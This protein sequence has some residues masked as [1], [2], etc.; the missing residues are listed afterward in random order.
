MNPSPYGSAAQEDGSNH[1]AWSA[2]GLLLAYR[3][4]VPQTRHLCAMPP[5]QFPFRIPTI[6]LNCAMQIVGDQDGPQLPHQPVA[7]HLEGLNA[8]QL[9]A[10][11]TQ[12][13]PLLMLAGAGTGK[14]RALTARIAHL[15]TTGRVRPYQILAV[16]F[17]NK[18]AS[19]MKSRLEGY[20]GTRSAELNWVGTF[21][22]ISGKILR[23]RAELVELKPDFTILDKMDQLRLLGQLVDAETSFDKKDFPVRMLSRI[24]DNWKN[25]GWTPEAVPEDREDVYGGRGVSLYKE[26]Q[27]RL[28]VLNSVD[29]GDLLL[30]TTEIF[31]SHPR[32][33]ELYQNRFRF[34]HVDEYQDTN[35]AQYLWLRLLAQSHR[36][37]CVVGDDS[38]SIYGWRGAVVQHILDFHKNFHGA[39][40]VRLEQN[41]RS[42][43]HILQAASGL[44]HH[45]GARLG[46]KLWS[47]AGDGKR[48]KIDE[49]F[50]P[51][52]EAV[53]LGK[54]IERLRETG[55]DGNTLDYGDFAVLV[56]A[57]FLIRTIEERFVKIGMPYRIVGG[58]RF[59][60]RKEVRDAI[61]YLRFA[62]S[63]D[64]GIAFE[65]IVN[66]P[67]AGRRNN[68]PAPYPCLRRRSQ[69]VARGERQE[70]ACVG[71]AP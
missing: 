7:P 33:L 47:A 28:K 41:Y 50:D 2:S 29:F 6:R 53:A 36:N 22:A 71:Q 3:M 57:T 58:L 1:A 10:V 34:I 25:R 60:E 48:V 35:V 31:K 38:Q 13:G 37:I 40:V 20:L 18:A 61:A 46:K 32:I 21:H 23:A 70:N 15:I 39:K 8:R 59:Y 56:R 69:S 67:P 54:S 27:D 30:H 12:D 14:T 43:N 66:F 49:H 11:E 19:E 44:I 55:I 26:Y 51:E 17:T 45:N 24:I 65:R 52:Q 5:D 64:D 4:A 9:E 42:A 68:D 16:T 62:R 63:F